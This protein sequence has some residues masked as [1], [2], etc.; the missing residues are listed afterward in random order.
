MSSTYQYSVD[1]PTS[2]VANLQLERTTPMTVFVDVDDVCANLVD[3]WIELYNEDYGDN[4]NPENITNCSIGDFTVPE[5]GDKIYEYLHLEHL[6]ESIVPID[7]ALLGVN[8]IRNKGHR[9]VFATTSCPIQMMKKYEWLGKWGFFERGDPKK[10]Y[11]TIGDKG[12]LHG[13][14]LIDD[15]PHNVKAFSGATVTFGR[16]WNKSGVDWDDIMESVW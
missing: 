14:V 5:C 9:V 2:E 13:H 4:L 12:L 3:R 11:I 15:G 6:Y 7:G 16:P 8:H 10:D 1:L